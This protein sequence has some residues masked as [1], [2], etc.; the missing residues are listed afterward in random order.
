MSSRPPSAS[1]IADEDALGGDRALALLHMPAPVR[2][3]VAAM[4]AVDVAMGDVVARATDPNLARIKL[5][6]WR[7]QLEALDG[8]APPAEPR[9]QAVAAEL[10]GRGIAGRDVAAL[11]PGWATLLDDRADPEHVAGRGVVLF[12]LG[13][14][15]LGEGD[16]KLGAAGA[17]YALTSVGR[18]GVPHLIEPARGHGAMLAGH[19]FPRA[20]RPLTMLAR[21][22]LRDL[23]GE[24]A[25][26][27]RGRVLAMLR[28]RWSGRIG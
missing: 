24:E 8:G 4:F 27:S 10:I 16:A 21:A 26:G 7:E 13:G 1:A 19:R 3:A 12:D 2:P 18:R 9:L 17:L 11:E 23:E 25:E 14:R 22:A 15:L 5:A 6:W 20:L 28:H